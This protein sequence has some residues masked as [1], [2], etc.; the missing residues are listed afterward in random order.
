MSIAS[1]AKTRPRAE[2]IVAYLGTKRDLKDLIEKNLLEITYMPSPNGKMGLDKKLE[3]KTA[4]IK[5]LLIT[6]TPVGGKNISE[7]AKVVRN[8]T[9]FA[10]NSWSHPTLRKDSL[11]DPVDFIDELQRLLQ[12]FAPPHDN[13]GERHSHEAVHVG[14]WVEVTDPTYLNHEIQVTCLVP[15]LKP[16]A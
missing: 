8:N 1:R 2:A 14:D 5:G 9:R 10:V 3:A 7:D 4:K 6:V 15:L 11:P 12:G 13:G 16:A